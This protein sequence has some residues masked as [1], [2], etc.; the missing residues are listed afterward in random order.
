MQTLGICSGYASVV[1]LSLYLTSDTVLDLYKAPEF[2]WCAVP[3][4]L[5]WVSWIWMRAH[6]GQM[7]DDPVVFAVKDKASLMAG[8]FFAVALTIGALGL[9]W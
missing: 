9:P 3:I 4:M 1:V 5:F 8:L 6:R 7:H 2:V